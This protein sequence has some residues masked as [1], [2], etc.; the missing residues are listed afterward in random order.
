MDRFVA[1]GEIRKK[2]LKEEYRRKGRRAGT[3]ILR[4]G[5]CDTLHST[6]DVFQATITA[7][8]ATSAVSVCVELGVLGNGQQ[9]RRG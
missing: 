4:P 7:K 3:F 5:N 2:L 1:V 8:E 9:S 6:S